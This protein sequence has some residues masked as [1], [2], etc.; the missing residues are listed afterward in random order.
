[1]S[2]VTKAVIPAAGYGTRLYPATK[3]VKKE[4][5]PI[6]D[7]A[8]VVKPV[9]QRIV[10]EA[11]HVGVEEVC[12]VVQ[13]EDRQLFEGYFSGS[14]RPDLERAVRQKPFARKLSEE[15]RE[16]G[17]RISYVVQE[18]Q[19]GFGHAVCCAR[20][21]VGD[22]PFLLMLGDHMYASRSAVPCASRLI[23]LLNTYDR[24]IL[25]VKR[26]PESQIMSFGTIVGTKVQDRPPVYIVREIKEKP[27]VSYARE[28]LR[29]DGLPIGE[30]LCLFGQYVLFPAIFDFIQYHI[31]NDIRENGEIQLTN[32]LEM[33]RKEDGGLHALETEDERYDIGKPHG[34]AR[35]V[36][37]FARISP[38]T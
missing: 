22:E 16:L 33:M 23:S 17:R 3:A 8:G 15:L 11:V 34:L 12:L 20:N 10:E 35:A 6:V 7:R 25:A 31:D 29:T 21:W 19:E 13:A 4:L 30:Y 36:T 18:E 24:S 27:D 28:H 38:R 1:M 14:L 37:D 32:A 2:K 5:F 26:T 9:I